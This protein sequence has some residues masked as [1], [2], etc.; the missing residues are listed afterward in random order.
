MNREELLKQLAEAAKGTEYDRLVKVEDIAVGQPITRLVK[1]YE[2]GF[3]VRPI[4]NGF[5]TQARRLYEARKILESA[6][7]NT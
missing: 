5:I 7:Q 2:L 6:N 3:G 1:R 4:K